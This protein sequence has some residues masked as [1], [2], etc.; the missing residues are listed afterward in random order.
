MSSNFVRKQV[1]GRELVCKGWISSSSTGSLAGGVSADQSGGPHAVLF[2]GPS[3]EVV[4]G[5]NERLSAWTFGGGGQASSS[6][7]RS[8][9]LR[10]GRQNEITCA[11]PLPLSSA[12][13][14]RFVDVF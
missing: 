14:N 13:A 6:S 9:D 7:R 10:I 4:D 5:G 1:P 8:P 11:C 3:L 2:R 12:S